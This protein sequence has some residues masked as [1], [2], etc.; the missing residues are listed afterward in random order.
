MGPDG[1][2]GMCD[3]CSYEYGDRTRRMVPGHAVPVWVCDACS[4]A[5]DRLAS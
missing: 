1:D 4:E 2:I 5:A 3:L